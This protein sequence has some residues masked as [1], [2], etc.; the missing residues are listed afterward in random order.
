MEVMRLRELD[1]RVG[2]TIPTLEASAAGGKS[3]R[4]SPNEV[5]IVMAVQT[6]PQA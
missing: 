5:P 3:G 6:T 1:G 2:S 4:G